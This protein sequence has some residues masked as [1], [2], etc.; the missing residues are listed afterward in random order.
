MI[1]QFLALQRHQAIGIYANTPSKMLLTCL[2]KNLKSQ[3]NNLASHINLMI[4]DLEMSHLQIPDLGIF[5]CQSGGK[6]LH[7]LRR[8]VL[9]VTPSNTSSN[10]LGRVYRISKRMI[11][12][13]KQVLMK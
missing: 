13:Y 2:N 9:R 6:H 11:Q 10:I 8:I 1:Q 3:K 4:Y 5:P 12:Y 7:S